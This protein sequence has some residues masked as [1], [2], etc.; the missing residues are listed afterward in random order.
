[1][2]HRLTGKTADFGSANRGSSPLAPAKTLKTNM[3]NFK[4]EE[5]NWQKLASSYSIDDMVDWLVSVGALQ[6]AKWTKAAQSPLSR[7]EYLRFAANKTIGLDNPNSWELAVKTV[8]DYQNEHKSPLTDWLDLCSKTL[9]DAWVDGWG[10]EYELRHAI[11]LNDADLRLVMSAVREVCGLG[12]Q[13]RGKVNIKR[14][15]PLPSLDIV[16]NNKFLWLSIQHPSFTDIIID[17]LNVKQIRVMF[18]KHVDNYTVLKVKPNFKTLGPLLGKKVQSCKAVFDSFTPE[19]VSNMYD[20]F[21]KNGSYSMNI[22]GENVDLIAEHV[23]FSITAINGV[24][25]AVGKV[26]T[27]VLD[28]RITEELIDEGLLREFVS[29]IQNQRKNSGLKVSDTIIMNYWASPR[30]AAIVSTNY[31]EI[32]SDCLI[33]ETGPCDPNADEIAVNN[34]TAKISIRKSP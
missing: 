2:G 3:I 20:A 34:E 32:C 8:E 29:I 18:N 21:E 13:A 9:Y 33:V 14:R 11:I 15:Q 7:L 4:A 12:L 24:I 28:T 19:I 30:L 5:K 25:A 31:N 26:G 17:E 10:E 16:T 23:E 22:D 27:V 6:E 1:M